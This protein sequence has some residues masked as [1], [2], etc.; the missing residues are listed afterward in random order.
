MDRKV[1]CCFM[2]FNELE[3]LKLKF[4]ELYDAV[5]YFVLS[6]STKTHSGLD[7]PLYFKENKHLFSKY[8]DKIIHQV[9]TDTPASFQTL[10]SMNPINNSHRKII[11]DIK[12]SYWF[13]K[14]VEGYIRDTYEKEMLF[15]PLTKCKDYDI[16]I[17]GDCDEIPKASAI[18]EILGSFDDNQ[19]Y[20]LQHDVF[21]YYLNL[22]KNEP[23]YGNIILSFRSFTMNSFNELRHAKRGVLIENGG[24]H[25]SYMG[26]HDK[27]KLKIES[28]GEQSC[29]TEKV[30]IELK[31][32]IENAVNLNRDLYNR[33]CKFWI[34]ELSY[35][36]HPKYLVDNQDEFKNFIYKEV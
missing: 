9:V 26:G 23:W 15:L 32:S 24:W 31:N 33:P 28:F 35:K 2:F 22:R 27:V 20:H 8:T 11:D 29:N 36:T 14:K 18:K 25:F 13:D 10:M 30:K 34:E 1:Y 17:L 16:I 3:L 5:D 21:Y 19:I 4:E 7:K 12:K 6:E